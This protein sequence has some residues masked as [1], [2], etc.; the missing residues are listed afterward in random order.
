M[1]AG[2]DLLFPRNPEK[3]RVERMPSPASVTGT[4]TA[5]EELPLVYLDDSDA[6]MAD[7]FD[8]DDVNMVPLLST[9]SLGC[10]CSSCSCGC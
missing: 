4:A 5:L 6:D 9:L 8:I 1:V 10:N 2:S 7:G 3:G